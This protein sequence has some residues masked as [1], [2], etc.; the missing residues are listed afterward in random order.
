MFLDFLKG[1]LG[2]LKIILIVGLGFAIIITMQWWPWW[3]FVVLAFLFIPTL[4][5]IYNACKT[6]NQKKYDFY[7][8][9][10]KNLKK[11]KEK[12][13]NKLNTIWLCPSAEDTKARLNQ[14]LKEI[15][16]KIAFNTEMLSKYE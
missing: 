8:N 4:F 12:I 7:L 16:D 3:L 6:Y 15:C 11:E 2:G 5:G 10:I 14:Q 13:L 1:F 9:E